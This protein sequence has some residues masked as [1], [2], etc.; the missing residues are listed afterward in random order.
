MGNNGHLNID[1]WF[2]FFHS[3]MKNRMRLSQM[4]YAGHRHRCQLLSK[5]TDWDYSTEIR[6]SSYEFPIT[7]AWI[8]QFGLW[9]S[10][11]Y[12]FYLRTTGSQLLWLLFPITEYGHSSLTSHRI[13][14]WIWECDAWRHTATNTRYAATRTHC[15]CFECCQKKSF[16]CFVMV[17]CLHRK[18]IEF[19]PQNIEAWFT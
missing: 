4:I 13:N 2:A 6:P 19:T 11:V 9:P 12:N 8:F 16:P 15:V 1:Q 14:L 3:A 17:M 10:T 5:S 7:A 18:F